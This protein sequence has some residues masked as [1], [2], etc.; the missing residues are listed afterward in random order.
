MEIVAD[1]CAFSWMKKAALILYGYSG[2]MSPRIE[3]LIYTEQNNPQYSTVKTSF[4]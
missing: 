1:F 4:D 3:F 2:V